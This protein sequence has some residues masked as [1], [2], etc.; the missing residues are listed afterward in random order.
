MI[1]VAAE[2]LT[3]SVTEAAEMLGI[4]KSS[5]YDYVRPGELPAIR[6]GR[7]LLVPTK[8]LQSLLDQAAA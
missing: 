3:V 1:N 4:S 2:R 5:A 8:A 6:M 7:R